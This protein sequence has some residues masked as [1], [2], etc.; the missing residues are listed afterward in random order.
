MSYNYLPLD[1]KWLHFKQVKN[2]LDY[3]QLVSITFDAHERI[4]KCRGYLDNKPKH[5]KRASYTSDELIKLIKHHAIGVGEEVALDIVKLMTMLKIKSLSYGQSGVQIE[6]VK[7]LMEMYNNEVFPVIHLQGTAGGKISSALSELCLPLIGLGEVWYK[8]QKRRTEV[9]F[10]EFNWQSIHLENDDVQALITGTHFISAYGLF[11]LKR[12]EQLLNVVNKIAALSFHTFN[13]STETLLTGGESAIGNKEMTDLEDEISKYLKG[14][15]AK[16]SESILNEIP[17][18]FINTPRSHQAAKETFDFVLNL[19]LKEINSVTESPQ[20][21]PDE[22]VVISQANGNAQPLSAA[23]DMLAISIAGLANF[24]E[25]RIRQLFHHSENP[26]NLS[27]TAAGLAIECRILSN[28]ASLNYVYGDA[29]DDFLIGTASLT[30]C[31]QVID[32]VEKIFAIELIAGVEAARSETVET[33]PPF[34][35]QMIEKFAKPVSSSANSIWD[36]D[37]SKAVEY[38]RQYPQ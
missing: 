35:R 32:R 17:N 27:S 37:I 11:I 21:F 25:G 10:A 2:L 5:D 14:R 18:S 3:N 33:D 8:G 26:Q 31:V 24:S 12:A 38:I 36:Y 20:F 28:P 9:V 19:F 7:R 6:T 34:L 4:L 23:L 16:K 1:R 30:K 15:E 13:F 22:D 29:T